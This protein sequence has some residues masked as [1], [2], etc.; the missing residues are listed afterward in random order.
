MILNKFCYIFAFCIKHK[1]NQDLSK[2]EIIL[3]YDN[4]GERP[5]IRFDYDFDRELINKIKT[6]KGKLWN[7]KQKFWNIQK[8]NMSQILIY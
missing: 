8:A 5:I 2:P 4:I 6:I 1:R 3:F 7:Q